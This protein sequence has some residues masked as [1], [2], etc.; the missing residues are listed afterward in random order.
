MNTQ[1]FTQLDKESQRILNALALM[2]AQYCDRPYGHDYMGA[3]EAAIE[4]LEDYGLA[5]E[6]VGV[7]HE[8]INKLESLL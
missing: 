4:V 2:Y 7:N 6:A 1:D 8:K 5:D 3:G